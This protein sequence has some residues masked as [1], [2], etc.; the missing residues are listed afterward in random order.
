M[1]PAREWDE[2]YL[3][4]LIRV[5]EQES[6]NLDYKQSAA[7][8]KEDKKKNELSK[9]VSAL[10][11]SAGGFLVYGMIEDGHVP[12]AIDVGV[13]RNV[14]SKEWL[15]SVINGSIK[16]AVENIVIQPISV[17]GGDQVVYVVEVPQATKR[18]PHQARDFRYYKRNNFESTPMEDYEVRDLMRRG[19]EYAAA[20]GFAWETLIEARRIGSVARERQ[21]VL[22]S[23]QN[24]PPG[25]DLTISVSPQMRVS[26]RTL[27]LLSKPDRL[28]IAELVVS[29]DGF[30]SLIEN[31]RGGRMEITAPMKDRLK[32]VVDLSDQVSAACSTLIQ[33]EP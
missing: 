25:S 23:L 27:I 12:T 16:P 22:I 9:D 28:K 17:G 1:R 33:N 15:E 21:K 18:A 29:V 6:L 24:A 3:N 7:L 10:A 31:T 19:L 20:V 32:A 4:Q 2:E 11:N 8:G 14:L 13:D 5:G 26:G 30:N